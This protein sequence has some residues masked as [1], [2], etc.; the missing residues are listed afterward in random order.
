LTQANLGRYERARCG[1]VVFQRSHVILNL[2]LLRKQARNEHKVL[3]SSVVYC[4]GLVF[5]HFSELRK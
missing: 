3:L 5:L 1:V 2:D 4:E